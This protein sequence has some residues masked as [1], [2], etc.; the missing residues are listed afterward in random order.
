MEDDKK[1]A[2]PNGS[3]DFMKSADVVLVLDDGKAIPCHSQLL[4]LHSAVLRNMLADLPARQP[5]EKV[6]IPLKDFTEAQC[7][8]LIEYL[9]STGVYGKGAAFEKHLDAATDVARFAHTYDAPHALQQ[10]QDY[11]IAFMDERLKVNEMWTEFVGM[12]S[13][14]DRLTGKLYEKSVLEWAIMADKFDMHELC[15]HCECTMVKYWNCFHNKPDLVDQMSSGMLKRIAKGLSLTLL[16]P[17]ETVY[18]CDAGNHKIFYYTAD[19]VNGK[20]LRSRQKYPGVAD[21]ISWRQQEQPTAPSSGTMAA[22]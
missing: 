6:E 1:L 21:Y 3:E 11:L 5:D 14:N 2:L 22:T 17:V 20:I 18:D 12:W 7:S 16:A 9:Y 15:G 8:V 10:I 19:E 13:L 4:S